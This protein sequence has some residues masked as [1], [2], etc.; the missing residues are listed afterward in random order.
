MLVKEPLRFTFSGYSIWLEPEQFQNDL[1]LACEE[2][3]ARLGLPHAVPSPHVTA[4][5]GMT[6]LSETEVRKRFQQAVRDLSFLFHDG[7]Q[8]QHHQWPVLQ[9]KGFRND[10]EI[11]GVNGGEMDMAWIENSFETSEKHETFLDLLYRAFY[12]RPEQRSPWCPHISFAYDNEENPIPDDVLSQLI[13]SYPTLKN[14]RKITG[15]SLWS[16]EGT[17]E[18]WKCLD[19]RLWQQADSDDDRLEKQ[20]QCCKLTTTVG[21]S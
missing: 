10:I 2:S 18:Q 7:N 19:R 16:T 21:A 17:I 13:N 3:T 1:D 14:N 11:N 5:Y 9:H 8:H 12:Q 15:I 6:H 4:I 20:P